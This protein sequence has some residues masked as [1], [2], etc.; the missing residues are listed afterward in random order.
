MICP[1]CHKDVQGQWIDTGIGPYEYW[2]AKCNDVQW[3]LF[4]EECE[5]ELESEQSHEDYIA[6]MMENSGR[7]RDEDE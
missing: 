4:C 3:A 2:G 5:E 7:Y 1:H 6:D